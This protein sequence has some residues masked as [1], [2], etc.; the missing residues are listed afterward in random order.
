M[1]IIGEIAHE[2]MRITIFY[3]NQKY[4]LKFELNDLEQTYKLSEFDYTFKSVEDLIPAVSNEFI[5]RVRMNFDEMQ[6]MISE[7]MG[8]FN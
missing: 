3:M 1:R 6:K 5:H 2:E 7:A 8:D 4:L